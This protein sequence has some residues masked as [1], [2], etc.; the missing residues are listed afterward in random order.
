MKRMFFAVILLVATLVSGPV[1]AQTNI[2][3]SPVYDSGRLYLLVTGPSNLSYSVEKSLDGVTWSNAPAFP[4][5]FMDKLAFVPAGTNALGYYYRARTS[6][7][8][9]VYYSTNSP[10]AFGL[11][12]KVVGE[13][14]V[15]VV[16]GPP[17]KAYIIEASTNLLNWSPV[18][19]GTIGQTNFNDPLRMRRFF[20]GKTQ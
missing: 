12:Q 18:L 13:N 11:T 17:N 19:I 7:N 15:V 9:I 20:R 8:S 16:N 1:L 10:I 6:S 3:L 14:A 5:F 2:N 4:T